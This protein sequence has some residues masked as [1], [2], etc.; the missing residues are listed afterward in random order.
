[1][2]GW[3][4]SGLFEKTHSWV[5]DQINGIKIRADRHDQNDNDF[6]SGLNNCMTKDG[7]NSATAD[8]D[9][10]GNKLKNGATATLVGDFPIASDIQNAVQTHVTSTGSANAYVVTL[11]P[12][13][14]A[15]VSGQTFTFKANF[16]NTGAA[17]VNVNG[18]GAKT[19]K[20][21]ADTTDLIANDIIIDQIV[22]ITY[23]GT[24]FQTEI[25]IT[26]VVDDPTPQLGG[27]LD[28]NSNYIGWDKGGDLASASPLVV[29]TD[30]N[31]FDVTGTTG[32]SV[33]T[34]ATNRKFTLQFDGILTLTNGASI[35][36]PGG[37]NFTTAAGDVLEC[38]SIAANTVIVTNIAKADGTAVV[39]GA[40]SVIE[41]QTPSAASTVTF[42]TGID[43]TFDYYELR[44]ADIDQSGGGDMRVRVE[45]AAAIKSGATDYVYCTLNNSSDSTTANGTGSTG[46]SSILNAA[47]ASTT[48]GSALLITLP[49]PSDT[50]SFKP[51]RF[52]FDVLGSATVVRQGTTVGFYKTDTGAITGLELSL[53]AGTIT[54]TFTLIGIRNS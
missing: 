36:L 52:D 13:P 22:T 7:Q 4:G 19:I 34:V 33:M 32:F 51:I 40:T 29:D 49:N 44:G 37:A 3:N 53:T 20:K 24:V 26:A 8:L 27:F 2:A 6:T 9:M 12:V 39:A 54:G 43:S 5:Q 41:T 38:Q 35:I 50:A 17:T 25:G 15:Y 31:M 42:N 11:T 47:N 45:V 28:P 10:G 48:A 18:L 23:D 16:A 30:G 21:S 46:D 14:A 1:M